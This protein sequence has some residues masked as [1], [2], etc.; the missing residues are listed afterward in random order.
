[1][2]LH[3][4]FPSN[5]SFFPVK[6][7]KNLPLP[8]LLCLKLPFCGLV[9]SASSM[10]SLRLDSLDLHQTH[11]SR[12]FIFPFTLFY[13]TYFSIILLLGLTL[14]FMDP[15]KLTSLFASDLEIGDGDS[16]SNES[17]DLGFSKWT[18]GIFGK[19]GMPYIPSN[20]FS[21]NC[22]FLVCLCVCFLF[23]YP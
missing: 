18:Q 12:V 15:Y 7:P 8:M 9:G 4:P 19:S 20:L 1:M 11:F 22:F 13:F 17:G 16:N 6:N 10:H 14:L 23:L 5:H 3:P 2:L 21:H